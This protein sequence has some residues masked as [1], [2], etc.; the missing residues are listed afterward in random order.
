MLIHKLGPGEVSGV[1]FAPDGRGLAAAAGRTLRVWDDAVAGGDPRVVFSNEFWPHAP[2]R[3]AADGRTLAFRWHDLPTLCPAAGGDPVVVARSVPKAADYSNAKTTAAVT[4]DGK[5]VLV[6][7][8][9][10]AFNGR[11]GHL[12]RITR[13]P[14]ANPLTEAAVWNVTTTN[15]TFDDPVVLAGECVTVEGRI[16]TAKGGW[17]VVLVARDLETGEV[18]RTSEPVKDGPRGPVASPDGRTV[19]CTWGK[20]LVVW[21]EAAWEAGPREVASDNKKFFTGVAFHP[22]GRFLAT[23]SND[24][25]AK[26]WDTTSWEVAKTYT[27]NVGRM[28]CVA[29]SPDGS[30]AAAGSDTGKVVVWDVDV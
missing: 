27:W 7:E 21:D 4:P 19:V 26:L 20:K 30:L 11:G 15:L 12:T 9:V 17:D 2:V 13:R 22:S 3:F 6:C 14:L 28:R 18:R 23:T 29:V 25:T 10:S 24:K 8:N 1:A 5:S 16:T